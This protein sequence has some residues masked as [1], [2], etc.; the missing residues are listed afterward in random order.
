M[1]SLGGDGARAKGLLLY[2]GVHFDPVVFSLGATGLQPLEEG[3]ELPEDLD[4]R[5]F[6]P[7]MRTIE[8]GKQLARSL[9]AKVSP[10]D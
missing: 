7:D 2:D 6:S 4:V 5:L 1:T 8:L 9:R 3:L 10:S